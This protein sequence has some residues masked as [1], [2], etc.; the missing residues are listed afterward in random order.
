LEIRDRGPGIPDGDKKRMF[1][2][3]VRQD[4]HLNSE[5]E[6]AGL[7][8]SIVKQM[9]ERHG[10]TVRILSREG[11]GAVFRLEFLIYES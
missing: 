9:V 11:G 5:T 8:L 7:G 1:E 4:M 2:A 10:G 6:G 3:F